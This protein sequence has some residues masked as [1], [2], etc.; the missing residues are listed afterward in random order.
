MGVCFCVCSICDIRGSIEI[1][2]FKVFV[3]WGCWNLII[4]SV[5]SLICVW[6]VFQSSLS[7]SS[8][9]AAVCVY[10]INC[11]TQDVHVRATL[12]RISD[13]IHRALIRINSSLISGITIQILDFI[14]PTLL[15]HQVII[16]HWRIT[17]LVGSESNLLY[18]Y[19]A[20]WVVALILLKLNVVEVY[21]VLVLI[22][23]GELLL[24]V[25][26]H[27]HFII[28]VVHILWAVEDAGSFRKIVV[29]EGI[30]TGK[31]VR[32]KLI[33]RV[34]AI[35]VIVLVHQMA[36]AQ[37]LEVIILVRQLVQWIILIQRRHARVLWSQ[38]SLRSV[39]APC[40][41][42]LILYMH[43]HLILVIKRLS[44]RFDLLLL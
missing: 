31:V 7:S 33:V 24:V 13:L 9:I 12:S 10:R 27:L 8:H 41:L 34:S 44:Q 2:H 16:D 5:L 28:H 23:L 39:H 26:L 14:R 40:D 20:F 38:S 19:N 25:H 6:S 22:V 32:L 11:L 15:Q 1:V 36:E 42:I 30:C 43:L 17:F 18:A 21:G 35:P 3:I 4:F 29:I 37:V